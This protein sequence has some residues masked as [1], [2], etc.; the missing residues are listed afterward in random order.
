MPDASDRILTGPTTA[1]AVLRKGRYAV[2][3]ATSKAD[4]ARAQALRMQCFATGGPDRDAWDAASTHFLV[5]DQGEDR[6]V[7]CF[8]T[9]LLTPAQAATES[10]SAQFYNLSA[11]AAFPGPVVELGRFCVH[12]DVTDPDVLRI[13]WG[14][15]AGLVDDEG[16]RL[17]MGCSSFAGVD[18][19]PYRECFALLSARHLAPAQWRP[20]SCATETV[21]FTDRPAR[22]FDSPAALS[23]MPPLL[24][25]YLTMGGW[26]SDHAVVD[27]QM[28]TLHV[29][30]GVEIDTIP[31]ARKHLLRRIGG[32]GGSLRREYF[33]K[34]EAAR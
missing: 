18:P 10:Y 7:C 21:K 4:V 5:T 31:V 27:R 24:R 1:Q 29:F 30:T 13:A 28:N 33:R 11:L 26:V 12:P 32:T 34:D 2:S 15:L 20:L 17:L 19:Y 23:P 6:L 9:R 22:A 3:R 8:R 25:S 16:V 14:A